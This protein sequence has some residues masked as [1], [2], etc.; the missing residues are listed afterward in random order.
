MPEISYSRL[1][2]PVSTPAAI[3]EIGMVG[4]SLEYHDGDSAKVLAINGIVGTVA[5]DAVATVETVIA[6]FS[7]PINYLAAGTMLNLHFLGQV[8]STA[9]L[10][11]KVR[12]GTTGTITDALLATFT[13]SAAGVANQHVSGD[14]LVTCL[15]SGTTGT[16]TAGGTIISG[17][18]TLPPVV[19][20]FAAATVNTT[21]V[22]IL[23][24]TLV[25]S[26]LQTYTSRAAALD[27][28]A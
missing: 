21:V 3:G 23:T 13:T 12:C 5:N 10:T 27:R 7:L 17:T 28:V 18:A 19:A 9:T 11:F 2:A 26:A 6:S 1:L 20:A 24:V 16:S 4:K 22:N 8:S 14:I 15:T 25:Q